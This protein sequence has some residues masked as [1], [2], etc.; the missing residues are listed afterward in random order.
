MFA[1]DP[2]PSG[3][4]LP[5]KIYGE[6]DEFLGLVFARNALE[7]LDLSPKGSSV[8]VDGLPNADGRRTYWAERWRS[9][10][11]DPDE[12]LANDPRGSEN[13]DSVDG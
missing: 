4:L 9:G 8:F 6:A 2:P 11:V 12:L 1:E 13:G 10:H 7:A 5:W 3:E